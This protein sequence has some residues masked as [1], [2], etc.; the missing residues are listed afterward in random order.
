MQC[1]CVMTAIIKENENE[2]LRLLV[3]KLEK[4]IREYKEELLSPDTYDGDTS[5]GDTS[6]GDVTGYCS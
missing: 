2:K 4:R 5:D 6:D 1:R 3:K